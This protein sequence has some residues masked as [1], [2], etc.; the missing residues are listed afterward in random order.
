MIRDT[1]RTV[2]RRLLGPTAF[3]AWAQ[4]GR[5][6]APH[7]RLQAARHTPCVFVEP[8]FDDVAFSCGGWLSVLAQGGSPVELVTVF[9]ADPVPEAVVSP[10]ADAV[11]AEWAATKTPYQQ[12]RQEAASIGALVSVRQT[13]LA[14]PEAIYRDPQLTTIEDLF[15]ADDP[16]EMD[17]IYPD[18]LS[19]LDESFSSQ[20]RLI[21]FAPLGVGGHQDHRVVH[22]AVRA[23]AARR[24]RWTV[25]YYEDFPYAL[26]VAAL[27]ARVRQEPRLRPATVEIDD[28]LETRIRLAACYESQVRAIF[29]TP[30]RLRHEIEGYAGRVG[31]PSAPRERYWLDREADVGEE[32]RRGGHPEA[33]IRGT[34]Q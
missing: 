26:D 27:K 11:H 16:P 8:H 33:T 34:K 17:P 3:D 32:G 10:L 22:A 20:S 30:D 23:L 28:T 15:R 1:L 7:A 2:G 21:V 31:T 13:S 19:A 4:F 14:L 25:W 29:G 9:T 24:P 5:P 12:R 18:V 6:P